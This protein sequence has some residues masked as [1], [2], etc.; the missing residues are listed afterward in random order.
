MIPASIQAEILKRGSRVG[1]SEGETTG[2]PA[3]DGDR[4]TENAAT[5]VTVEKISRIS[6]DCGEKDCYPAR[7]KPDQDQ[8]LPSSRAGGSIQ[9]QIQLEDVNPGIPQDAEGSLVGMLVH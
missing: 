3:S 9:G 6:I 8:P 4:V 7:A 5:I 2:G 1:E